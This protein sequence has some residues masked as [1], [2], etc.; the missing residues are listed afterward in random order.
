MA[1]WVV[2]GV[3]S[4]LVKGEAIVERFRDVGKNVNLLLVKPYKTPS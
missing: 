2:K 1:S 3:L 4:I